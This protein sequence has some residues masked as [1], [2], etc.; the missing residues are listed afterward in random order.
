MHLIINPEF[1]GGCCCCAARFQQHN[2]YAQGVQRARVFI[3]GCVKREKRIC[4]YQCAHTHMDVPVTMELV[5]A[6]GE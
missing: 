6:R 5:G 1:G 4:K 2:L 3:Q